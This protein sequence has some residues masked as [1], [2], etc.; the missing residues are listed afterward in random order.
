MKCARENP[1]DPKQSCKHCVALGI[2]CT[3]DYQPK[4]RGVRVA[5]CA[6]ILDHPNFLNFSLQICRFHL[7]NSQAYTVDVSFPS[8]Y[9]R[10]LQEAAAAAN[11]QQDDGD[12]SPSPISSHQNLASPVQAGLSPTN[13]RQE[14][15][16]F[17]EPSLQPLSAITTL[18]M[19]PSRYPIAADSFHPRYSSVN[20]LPSPSYDDHRLLGSLANG[21]SLGSPHLRNIDLQSYASPFE[22]F[23]TYPLYN[24]SYKQHQALHIPS[25]RAWPALSLYY[26]PHRLEEIAPRETISLIVALF[27]DF[28]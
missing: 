19:P 24:W 23:S 7:R 26:R 13:T 15:A 3:Y 11:G 4:K 12:T 2:P 18:P 22:S 20:S 17:L 21:N 6:R 1:D 8:R 25:S 14:P 27:F 5:N 10:R 9:L 16:P 28:V